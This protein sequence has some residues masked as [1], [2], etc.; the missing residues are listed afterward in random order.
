MDLI[1]GAGV[2]G[3]SYALFC[4]NDYRI[5][6]GDEKIGGYCKTTKRNGFVWDYSGHF[7]HF[8]NKEIERL[9]MGGIPEN[10][11][12]SVI[13]ETCI[14]YKDILV[15]YPFQKNIHQ[16]S[17]EELIECL[18]DLFSIE[19]KS[20]ET[21]KEMLY[22]KFGKGIAE[23]FLIPYNTKLYACDLNT[24]DKDAM[25]RFFPYA[26][27][28]D[29]IK[30]FKSEHNNSYNNSFVYPKGGAIEYINA[31]AKNVDPD[32]IQKNISVIKIDKEA[33]TVLCSNG[34]IIAYNRLIS[35][36]PFPKL[37]DISNTDY[38]SKIYNWNQVL[39]FNL[40]FDTKGKDTENHWVYFPEK[41][42]CFY[43]IGFY[44]NILSQDRMS[45]YIELGFG[46]NEKIQPQAWLPKVLEDLKKAGFLAEN[47]KLID[48]E[49]LVMNPAYVH[50]NQHS[51]Q[52]VLDKKQFL[53]QYGIYSI[54]RYGSWTYC[55]IEDNIIEAKTLAER[56]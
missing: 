1:I 15:D 26:E 56:L 54:G 32:K 14:K 46:K 45:M 47:Q 53:E 4:K 24:L 52:D 43:R 27:K 40:G 29:I 33:K 18:Y 28:E 25:G 39:V 6:E 36:M 2:T 49:S 35:T 38:D 9:V 13:K 12:V 10:E 42:Y 48:Y 31:I 55:S 3:L 22:V 30:N 37:L 50:I 41:E 20:Y 21:F 51:V 8:R 34:E 16:L 23:K 44:D 5:L 19:K 11:L 17:K 7:F